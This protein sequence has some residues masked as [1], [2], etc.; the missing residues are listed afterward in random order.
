MEE[1]V[2]KMRL[3]QKKEKMLQDEIDL[4]RATG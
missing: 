3:Y 4:M 2:L 1:C